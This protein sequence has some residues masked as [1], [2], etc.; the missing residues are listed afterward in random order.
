MLSNLVSYKHIQST[1]ATVWLIEHGLSTDV[2]VIDCWIDVNGEI[3]RVVP[4]SIERV[5]G[6]TVKA[7]F[8]SDR[9]GFAVV[10]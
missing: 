4:K 5:D 10:A 6:S 7:I 2:P 1:P 3:V 8:S 9:T